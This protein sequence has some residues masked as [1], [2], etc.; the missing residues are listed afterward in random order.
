MYPRER[1]K[2]V[3]QSEVHSAALSSLRSLWEPKRSDAVVDANVDYR[4]FLNGS[5]PR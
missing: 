4:R 1:R 3:L 2:L 5:E